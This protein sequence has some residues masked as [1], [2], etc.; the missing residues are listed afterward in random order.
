MTEEE[1]LQI[2]ISHAEPV[3]MLDGIIHSNDF[4]DLAKEIHEEILK[5]KYN[6]DLI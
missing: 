3:T 4:K 1:I 5:K 2:I 6:I